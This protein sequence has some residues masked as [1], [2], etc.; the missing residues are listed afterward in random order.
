MISKEGM[1]WDGGKMPRRKMGQFSH[2]G[3]G[4]ALK[5]EHVAFPHTLFPGKSFFCA[6]NSASN[7]T[8]NHLVFPHFVVYT[9]RS[10]LRS[11]TRWCEVGVDWFRFPVGSSH[12]FYPLKTQIG[13]S[14][15]FFLQK[16]FLSG[17]SICTSFFSL[18]LNIAQLAYKQIN[19]QYFSE[20]IAIHLEKIR[21]KFMPNIVLREFFFMCTK[22]LCQLPSGNLLTL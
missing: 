3:S 8:A 14:H 5:E 10:F 22:T 12:I 18:Y 21:G 9:S 6:V 7:G 4:K 11:F 19:M 2:M 16:I 20:C 17:R 13:I 1:S 15:Y